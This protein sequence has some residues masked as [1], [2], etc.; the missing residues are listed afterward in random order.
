[1]QKRRN[2]TVMGTAGLF[3]ALMAL[4]CLWLLVGQPA[5]EASAQD[6]VTP[7]T[8]TVTAPWGVI[9]TSSETNP[10][11]IGTIR[12]PSGGF[13]SRGFAGTPTPVTTDHID[14][15]SG[16]IR[17]TFTPNADHNP[18]AYK[19]ERLVTGLAGGGV[20]AWRT[21]EER[22][23]AT[24]YRDSDVAANF[25]YVYRITPILADDTTL[26]AERISHY[27]WQRVFLYGVGTTDGVRLT[28]RKSPNH[29][30]TH[31][32]VTITRYN[33]VELTNG[34]TVL[35]NH[36]Y[37]G[38]HVHIADGRATLGRVY[39]YH[40]QISWRLDADEPWQN[41][42]M[43]IDPVAVKAGVSVPIR[44]TQ[45]QVTIDQN[46][47]V[48]VSWSVPDDDE[49]ALLYEVRRRPIKPI[50]L[51]TSVPLGTTTR[52]TFKYVTDTPLTSYEYTVVPLNMARQFVTPGS[53]GVTFPTLPLPLCYNPLQ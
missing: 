37:N 44:P 22:T 25:T 27:A 26:V 21:L 16:Y 29:S 11:G 31:Q 46:N 24:R 50:N 48:T 5:Q 49:Q 2:A 3:A 33:N 19:L 20:I 7:G 40:M 39:Y 53:D 6:G 18:V 34:H 38:E 15:P 45:T 41:S 35:Q 52:K 42:P 1:M 8:N 12:P 9:T 23:T 51:S 17:V 14:R 47:L 10:G 43:N 32:S 13:R 28:V 36:T 4:A 30:R